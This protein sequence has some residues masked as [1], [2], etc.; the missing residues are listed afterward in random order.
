MEDKQCKWEEPEE[1]QKSP[2]WQ[3]ANDN[4]DDEPVRGTRLLL[5]NNIYVV[6]FIKSRIIFSI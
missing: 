1:K 5:L 2:A 4:I 6:L 3:N